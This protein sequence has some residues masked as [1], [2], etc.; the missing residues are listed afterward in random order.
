M[1]FHK[2]YRKTNA[3]IG[4][5]SFRGTRFMASGALNL[6]GFYTF[7]TVLNLTGFY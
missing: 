6:S 4:L 7:A 2:A 3:V 5:S 1:I